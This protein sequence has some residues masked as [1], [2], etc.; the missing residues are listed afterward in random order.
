VESLKFRLEDAKRA[1]GTLEE[2]L[3]QP[4]SV[5]VRDATIQ[6]F[7]YSFE[8]VWKLLKSFL[9]E[10]EGVMAH[11]PK[12]CFREMPGVGLA[13]E[14][15]VAQWLEM[16]DRRNETAHTYKEEV[17]QLIFA[18]TKVFVKLMRSLLDRIDDRMKPLAK[19]SSSPLR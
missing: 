9:L 17:A 10:K 19:T 1:V 15:E 7:E 18:K 6:R 2:I 14:E 13:T 8:A 5:I 11:S 12:S 4:Y 3:R 16:T